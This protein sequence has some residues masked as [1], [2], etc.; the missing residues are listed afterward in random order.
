[1]IT[2]AS[3]PTGSILILLLALVAAIFLF[4]VQ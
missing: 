3:K 1:M 2:T 4:L